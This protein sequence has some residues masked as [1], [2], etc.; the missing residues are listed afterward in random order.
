[1]ADPTWEQEERA[2]LEA[3]VAA[4]LE[5]APIAA[6]TVLAE[7]LG[8]DVDRVRR[9]LAGLVDANYVEADAISMW[10]EP[11]VVWRDLKPKEL[12]RREVGQWPSADPFDRLVAALETAIEN[13][14]DPD[15]RDRLTQV[16]DSIGSAGRDLVIGAL[17]SV[18]A[19]GITGL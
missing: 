8:W 10:Q 13:E 4:D 5:G 15:R 6:D 7:Q 1:M 11:F 3:V 14:P 19:T 16:R 9:V 2:V 12:A 17:G 18:L